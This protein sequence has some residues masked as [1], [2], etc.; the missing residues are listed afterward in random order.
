MINNEDGENMTYNARIQITDEVFEKSGRAFFGRQ[1]PK[2][3]V[4]TTEE[5]G[6]WVSLDVPGDSDHEAGEWLYN[7]LT[8]FE[9]DWSMRV[10]TVAR[11]DPHNEGIV[12]LTTDEGRIVLAKGVNP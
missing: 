4:T 9:M 11:N 6:V 3:E 1:V 12:L 7:L 8:R 2:H 5:N 10:G